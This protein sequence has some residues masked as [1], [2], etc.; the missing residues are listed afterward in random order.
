MLSLSVVIKII[1]EDFLIINF[2]M[3]LADFGICS[4]DRGQY[5]VS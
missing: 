1:R 3:L 5:R 2:Y 4:K